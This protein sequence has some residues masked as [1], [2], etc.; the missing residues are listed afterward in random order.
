MTKKVTDSDKNKL[1]NIC[2]NVLK[3]IE[4]TNFIMNKSMEEKVLKNYKLLLAI[5]ENSKITSLESRQPISLEIEN[6]SSL[7]DK[8][9]VTDK[10]DGDRYFLITVDDNVYL[11]SNNLKVRDTGIVL[12]SSLGKNTMVQF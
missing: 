9:A 3:M 1:Y 5:N 7:P 2:E 11:I 6:V 12:S 8:Y 4:K 10:A